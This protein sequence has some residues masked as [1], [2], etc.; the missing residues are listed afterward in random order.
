MTCR[1]AAARIPVV[2][3]GE[4]GVGRWTIATEIANDLLPTGTPTEFVE[5]GDI[6]RV[7]SLQS[8]FRLVVRDLEKLTGSDQQWLA[9]ALSRN[10]RHVALLATSSGSEVLEPRLAAAV[11]DVPIPPLRSRTDLSEW[12]AYFLVEWDRSHGAKHAFAPDAL[13]AIA[14]YAW[15]GNFSELRMRVARGATLAAGTTIT[16]ED[17]GFERNLENRAILPLDEA[18][19][20]FKIQYV[21]EVLDRCRGNRTHAARV[22]GVDPRTVFRFLEASREKKPS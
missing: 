2:L 8:A 7:R 5:T 4:W 19:Q 18:V 15:P 9:D 14:A 20:A 1:L 13:S 11:T 10:E 3:T 22:L 17:L 6:G 12:A 21:R 16:P